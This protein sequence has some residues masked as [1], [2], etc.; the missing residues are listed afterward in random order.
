MGDP[1]PGLGFT[2]EWFDA[3]VEAQYLRARWYD[4]AT[5][6]FTSRDPWEGDRQQPLTTNSYLYALDSPTTY[7][8]PS[9]YGPEWWERMLQDDT[10]RTVIFDSSARHNITQM[11]DVD[12]AALMAAIIRIESGAIHHRPAPYETVVLV[13]SLEIGYNRTLY[14]GLFN[15]L[16][17]DSQ[18]GYQTEGVSNISVETI[19]NL[20][21]GLVPDAAG[22]L[23]QTGIEVYD[24]S[25]QPLP[26]MFPF[27]GL[28]KEQQL[29]ILLELTGLTYLKNQLGNPL[30]AIPWT[31]IDISSL[32]QWVRQDQNIEYL[33]A[34]L[35]AGAIR[36][37]WEGSQPTAEV[38]TWW[39][40]R[41]IVTMQDEE[42]LGRKIAGAQDPDYQDWLRNVLHAQAEAQAY[43]DNLAS[44]IMEEAM[45]LLNR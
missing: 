29:S 3:D 43:W 13:K 45:G 2:G 39:H 11:S 15:W 34:N 9:G 40:F 18:L 19:A 1:Q 28:T 41:G 22:N 37:G 35:E 6:R 32:L 14:P 44:W 21:R 42:E 12:F 24:Y 5:G 16:G 10:W 4:V 23:R 31:C 17:E 7:I 8:D 30:L 26:G 38:L 36:A 20:H 27:P 33:A 25:G